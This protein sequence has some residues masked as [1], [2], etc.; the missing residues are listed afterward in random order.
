MKKF[1]EWL[2]YLREV[3]GIV[4]C[5]NVMDKTYYDSL[6]PKD[7]YYT[8]II[9]FQGLC[10]IRADFLKDDNQSHENVIVPWVT[11]SFEDER[12]KYIP[13]EFMMLIDD[14]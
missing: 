7:N 5:D 4:L 11:N 14:R 10:G 2:K 6:Y 3:C 13:E 9:T 12:E 1:T 8:I